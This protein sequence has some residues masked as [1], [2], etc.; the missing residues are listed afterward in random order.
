MTEFTD[1]Q[2]GKYRIEAELGR[3]GFGTVFRAVDTSLERTVALKILDPLLMRNNNWVMNFRKEARV[4]AKLE[5]PYIVP[6]YETGEESGRLYIAMKLIEGGNLA[7][8]IQQK[9]ALA[10]EETVRIIQE[11]VS[12]LDFAHQRQVIHRDLKPGNI[13]LGVGGSVLT[14]FGFARLLSDNSMSLS[15]SGGIV[16]TPAYI[17]PEIWEGKTADKQA[18]IYSLGCILYEMVTGKVL[19]TGDSVPAIMLSHFKPL[20]LPDIWPE[21]VPDRM[22]DVLQIALNREP[23]SRYGIAGEMVRDLERLTRNK[24]EL[25]QESAKER[26]KHSDI[27]GETTEVVTAV[28]NQTTAD[29][30]W[31]I[32]EKPLTVDMPALAPLGVPDIHS[33]SIAQIDAEKMAELVDSGKTVV[34]SSTAEL[35]FPESQEPALTSQPSKNEGSLAPVR[36]KKVKAPMWVWGITAL[37]VTLV[38]AAILLSSSTLNAPEND[39]TSIP[40]EETLVT[41]ILDE[42]ADN[43]WQVEVRA[44]VGWQD[45]GITVESGDVIFVQYVTGDWYWND[46]GDSAVTAYGVPPENT[47]LPDAITQ[48]CNYASLVV[49]F[50]QPA[51]YDEDQFLV[52]EPFCIGNSS[53]IRAERAGS[54]QVRMN[55]ST[56]TNNSGSI[57]IRIQA[58]AFLWPETVEEFLVFEN[59][60]VKIEPGD[61]ERGEQLYISYGCTACHGDPKVEGSNKVGPWLGN[62]SEVGTTRQAGV[63]SLQYGYTSILEPNSYISPNCPTGLCASPSA[64][65]FRYYVDMADS[66]QDMADLLAFLF[67][68]SALPSATPS[69][70]PTQSNISL[71]PDGIKP[72]WTTNCDSRLDSSQCGFLNS[73]GIFDEFFTS[74]EAIGATLVYKTNGASYFRVWCP[75]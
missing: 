18:D 52:T 27:A 11:V 65:P 37:I 73:P 28:L 62:V 71:T 40:T 1:Q 55:D 42:Q 68:P 21:T 69:L 38:M 35:S 29:R 15:I 43:L 12:A 50:S 46:M 3:G 25:Y 63:S 8:T 75:T 49:R 58:S 34:E 7:T 14:D 39:L 31:P 45:T 59:N 60:E 56:P 4:M 10:W 26:E 32:T 23:A 36:E 20:V 9:G 70:T 44:D 47:G 54:L 6:I 72:L 53:L 24:A 64:M 22:R 33:D 13:L 19:F 16:G 17:A 2:F 74:I 51:R 61:R 66:P 5:H 57:H 67:A 48:N 41:A 30:Q